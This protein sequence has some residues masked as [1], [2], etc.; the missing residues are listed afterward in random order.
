MHNKKNNKH[1]IWGLSLH[2]RGREY[3]I[4]R[5]KKGMSHK[6]ALPK[7]DPEENT[8]NDRT[9]FY[10]MVVTDIFPC[11]PCNGERK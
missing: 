7:G 2:G 11:L 9:I 5:D 3:V 1:P 8:N 4:M 10:R 6:V